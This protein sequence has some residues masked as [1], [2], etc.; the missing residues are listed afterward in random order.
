MTIRHHPSDETLLSYAAGSLASGPSLIIAAH[1]ECCAECRL[2]V[3]RME[4]AAGTMLTEI[5]PAEL[6]AGALDA[7]LARLDRPVALPSTVVPLPVRQQP[8]LE[9]LALPMALAAC[10]IGPWRRVAPGVR[11]SRVRVPDDP[12][13]KVIMLRVA[14]GKQ[15]PRHG[16][17][18]IEF[19][20]V[21]TGSF[22]D[23]GN[24][25]LPGDFVEA[26]EGIDHQPVIGSGAECISIAAVEG[27]IQFRGL[28]GRL[29]SPFAGL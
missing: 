8:R 7:V 13:A 20:Q 28:I 11:V 16:H 17:T 15:M 9:E 18:G 29:L 6:S 14:A 24:R 25:Y 22:S 2:A 5:A 27:R 4:A 1:L 26:E 23:T 19:T 12:K 10:D 21:L 3:A